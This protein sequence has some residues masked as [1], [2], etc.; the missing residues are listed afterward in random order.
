MERPQLSLPTMKSVTAV[1]LAVCSAGAVAAESQLLENALSCK[2]K[3]GE[4]P[5]LMRQLTAQ[6]AAFAKPSQQY[7]APSADVYQLPKPVTAFG[8]ASSEVVVT[9]GRILLAVPG[10]AMAKAVGK[11]KLKE[12]EYSPARREVRPTVNVVAFQLSHKALE[13]KLLVGCEYQ[14]ADAARWVRS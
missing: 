5:A 1:L 13:N 9:P 4:L 6:Q 12:E 11:L 7:G 8:Y 14:H 2:L 10:E 3:D